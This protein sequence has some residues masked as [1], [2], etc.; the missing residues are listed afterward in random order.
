MNLILDLNLIREADGSHI[1]G[2]AL[3]LAVLAGKGM[4]IPRAMC[5]TREAY[6]AYVGSTGL[7]ERISLELSRKDFQDMRWEELWDASLR[8]R[9]MFLNTPMQEPLASVLR[10]ALNESF[11]DAPVAVRSSAP[12]EDSAQASFAGLHESYLNVR[13]AYAVID[14]IRLVWASLW[15]DAALLYRKELG[16]DVHHSTMAVIVQELVAGQKSGVV[17]GINPADSSQTVV[18]AIHGLNQG[19]V[20]GTIEPDR[21]LIDR[22]NGRIISHSPAGRT[23]I[24]VPSPSGVSLGPLPPEL[25]QTPPLSIEE[26]ELVNGL[27]IKA[28]EVFG[29]PQDVEWTFDGNVLYTLQSRPITAS[30]QEGGKDDR[31]W[32]RSLS[33]SYE[34]L[35]SLRAKIEGELIPGMIQDA[36]GLDDTVLAS[37]SDSDL[38]LEIRR[39]LR[40]NRQWDETYRKYFIPFAHGMRLFGR[41]Y[42]DAVR[43]HDPYEFMDLLGSP[44][45]LSI[46]RNRML[47]HLARL[48][49]HDPGL[50]RA[51]REAEDLRAFPAFARLFREFVEAFGDLSC[52]SAQCHEGDAPLREIVLEMSSGRAGAPRAHLRSIEQD[53]EYF[54]SF[55]PEGRKAFA[56]DL[57]DL[58]KASYR[59]RDDDNIY[60]GRIKGRLTAAVEEA[61]RRLRDRISPVP[62]GLGDEA[63][64]Q[65]L[66]DPEYIPAP[67]APREAESSQ[68]GF[69][70][71]ARQLVGQPAGS[72]IATG[73]ARVI[74]EGI[75]LSGFKAGEILVCDALDPNMTFMVPLAAGIV[76]RRGGMLIH[77]AIIAREYGL[78]CVTGVPGATTLIR[79]G[80]QVT[81]DGY[82]GIVVIS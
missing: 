17:F 11:G 18:E 51:L 15:S 71:K 21:W 45:M 7:R 73:P 38:A 47:E 9:N 50:A 76:E 16:L 52:Y 79:T 4:R 10:D 19:L 26:V 42:N 67:P 37:S 25:T 36:D 46:Q 64:L 44:D 60:L 43:P 40:I 5:V 77:G 70:L 48:V 55:F 75:G 39:R 1:G 81:V 61:R 20:D 54:L 6:D 13:G 66:E 68:E 31:S 14:H 32:Y 59:L 30:L 22:S 80:D 58:A 53:E 78:P 12:G 57:L 34:N 8:I 69:S 28:E 49:M 56:A 41:V 65:V 63:V 74:L 82:L 72:G 29:N 3:A 33:R 27:A 62:E 24:V 35:K 23:K 2:K